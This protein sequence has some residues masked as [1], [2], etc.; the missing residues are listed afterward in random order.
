MIVIIMI[1]GCPGI[2]QFFKCL[3]F[4]T[5]SKIVKILKDSSLMKDNFKDLFDKIC[6]YTH[7]KIAE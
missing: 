6:F 3:K 7:L 4:Y 2:L 1:N 5:W